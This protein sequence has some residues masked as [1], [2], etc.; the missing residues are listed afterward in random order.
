MR[1]IYL[2]KDPETNE[3][4]YVGQTDNIKRRFNQHINKCCDVKNK[5]YGTHKNCWIRKLLSNNLKPIIEVLEETETLELSNQRERFWIEK[6]TNEGVK[7]TNSYVSDVTEFSAETKDK[8]SVAKKGKKLEEIVGEE[9][10][11]ELKKYYSEK[12]SL[13]NPNKS[14]NPEVK[15]KISNTLKEFFKDKTNH[16]A[17]GKEMTEEAKEKTRK[18]HLNNPK[19]VGNKKPRTEE[20]KEKLRKAITGRTVIRSKIIQYDLEGNFIKKWKSIREICREIPDYNRET[21]NRNINQNKTYAGF[22]WKKETT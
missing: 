19:N 17:F 7:L 9:K 3:I 4:R 11:K 12:I 14:S 18:S 5:Q 6:L 2:L 1:Y 22:I 8:M 10:A 20:Q 16:W 21:L 13:N 15:Q